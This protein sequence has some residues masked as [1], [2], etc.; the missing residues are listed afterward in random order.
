MDK[1]TP[2]KAQ[3]IMKNHGQQTTFDSEAE[4]VLK[5]MRMLASFEVKKYLASKKR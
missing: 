3:E 4:E 5:F 2:V 1:M